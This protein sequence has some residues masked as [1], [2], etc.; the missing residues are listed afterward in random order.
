MH[1]VSCLIFD[2]ILE[3]CIMGNNR[4]SLVTWLEAETPIMASILV[5]CAGKTTLIVF[6]IVHRDS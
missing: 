2:S 3:E 1:V 6:D 4:F 5:L